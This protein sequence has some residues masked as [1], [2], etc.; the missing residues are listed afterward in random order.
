[1]SVRNSINCCFFQ[2]PDVYGVY[3]FKVNY[4][5]LGLTRISTA[6]Q[7]ETGGCSGFAC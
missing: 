2:I 4:Y 5:R 3:Q 1:M 6:N 7:V